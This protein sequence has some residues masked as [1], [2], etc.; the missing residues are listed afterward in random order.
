M[1]TQ[2]DS[3]QYK[4]L[5]LIPEYLQTSQLSRGSAGGLGLG[6]KY[7]GEGEMH[8]KDSSPRRVPDLPC[9]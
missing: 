8:Q 4:Y 1:S 3:V 7:K 9:L 5:Q 2:Q 6:I